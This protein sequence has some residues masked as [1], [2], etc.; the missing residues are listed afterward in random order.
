MPSHNAGA[1]TGIDAG[2]QQGT[3]PSEMG[4]SAFRKKKG[5]KCLKKG[6]HVMCP[7]VSIQAVRVG[8][9][10]TYTRARAHTG[11]FRE[12]KEDLTLRGTL[13]LWVT[14]PLLLLSVKCSTLAPIA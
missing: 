7:Q 5:S 13:S 14:L 8:T 10:L 3:E 9:L 1:R 6:G 4:S 11:V 12:R 2:K